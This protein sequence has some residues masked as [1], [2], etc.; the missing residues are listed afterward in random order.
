MPVLKS[1]YS[2]VS[3][4]TRDVLNQPYR[5]DFLVFM[6]TSQNNENVGYKNFRE[7]S[8]KPFPYQ[9]LYN[10]FFNNTNFGSRKRILIL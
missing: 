3:F 5:K 2:L 4:N 9:L 1:E 7:F 6:S 8:P 10:F